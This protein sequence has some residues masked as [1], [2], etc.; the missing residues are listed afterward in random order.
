MLE[1]GQFWRN[2]ELREHVAVVENKIAPTIVFTNSTYLNVYTKSWIQANIWIYKDRIVYVGDRMPIKTDDTDI[3]DCTGQYLVPGYIEP[4]AH[5]FQLYNPEELALHAGKF[6]TTTLINDNLRL[7]SLFDEKKAFSI[8]ENFHKLAISMFWWGRYDSQSMLR[9]NEEKFN[10][11]D[12][13]SW[14]SHPSVVQG[15]ELTSWPQLLAG[16]DRLLYW[17]QETKRLNKRVEGHFPGAS[18]DTLTK[19]KL[20]GASAD[21]ESMTGE[22]VI[23]RLQLGYHV[24]LRYS[25]IR[26][27]LPNILEQLQTEKI[28]AYDQMMYTTD[29]STPSFNER[30]LINVC[31]KIA[32]ERGVPLEDAYRMATYNVAK[33]Y[34]LDELLGSIA[35]GRLAHINIL[36]EKDD[37][38]PL[39]VLAKGKWIV[40][41]GVEI[42]Q[43]THI[44]WEKHD[45]KKAEFQWELTKDDL[46][47]S[48]PIGLKMENDV[49][50]KPYA[51]DI[52]IT[53]DYLP[54]GRDDA[55]LL[56]IDRYGKWR[57]NSVIHGFTKEL[58]GLCSTYST[59]DD[60][61]IIGKRKSDMSLAWKRMKEI[62]GGIVLA[63]QGKII[64]EL[65]LPLEGAMYDGS[66]VQLIEKEKE[67]VKILN[68]AGYTFNDPIYTLLFLSSTHLPYIR[69][70]Q[71]GIVDVMKYE[72]IVPANMR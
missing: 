2:R 39:S 40:R 61:I 30:G 55:F 8:I 57:V 14:V 41:D 45:I 20:L 72:V 33:Y 23:R 1:Q 38:H 50:M 15:G 17:I 37:P 46:Q 35:P 58:G 18:V 70:T 42:E 43:D 44:N 5:P 3:I 65:A 31:I 48:I 26:P 19:L 4:H 36:Y 59:T 9:D 69:I 32:L 60:I 52:D 66:M 6:G 51:V 29:G 71:Q 11:N 16:D 63:H 10:T 25:C 27:D 24:A 56:L 64:Y 62:G 34:Q 53:A 13:L 47:F 54:S 49:I 22:E 21:H 68:E 28:A 7:L 67:C 12:I